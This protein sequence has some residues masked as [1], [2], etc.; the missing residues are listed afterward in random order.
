MEITAE[1]LREK[2]KNG[3][4]VIVD[5]WAEF[6]GPCKMMKPTFEKVSEEIN[7]N[8]DGV[9]MYTMDV[10]KN[11]NYAVELGIRSIPTIK[12]FSNGKEV[13]SKVG[14]HGESQIKDL[15]KQLLN[16]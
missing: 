4:K 6:C 3:D 13:Y 11:Q 9:I 16:G 5:F 7:N 1:Q 12:S 10:Q 14:I 15:A 8:K 2:I